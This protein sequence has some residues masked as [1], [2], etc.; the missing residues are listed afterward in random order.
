MGYNATISV[1][2][3]PYHL[4]YHL[5]IVVIQDLSDPLADLAIR[6]GHR[7]CPAPDVMASQ[8]VKAS[9]WLAGC[10]VRGLLGIRVAWTASALARSRRYSLAA[11]LGDSPILS[12]EPGALRLDSHHR[13]TSVFSR[14]PAIRRDALDLVVGYTGL[15]ECS[16]LPLNNVRS[17]SCAFGTRT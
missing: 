12:V 3:L 1:R 4:C 15:S 17:S 6:A 10:D 9:A 8:G 16:I 11:F 7:L 13:A 14:W 2:S 5:P